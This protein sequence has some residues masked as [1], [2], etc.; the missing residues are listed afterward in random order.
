MIK[1]NQSAIVMISLSLFLFIGYNV[2]TAEATESND[3][4]VCED[5]NGEWKNIGGGEKGC[6]FD[7]ES[8]REKYSV[9]PGYSLDST[10]S[11]AEYGIEDLVTYDNE[12]N[13]IY[14][15]IE[16][17]SSEANPNNIDSDNDGIYDDEELTDEEEERL[18]D[19]PKVITGDDVEEEEEENDDDDDD[20]D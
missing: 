6:T 2:L 11:D 8:D 5:Y 12:G 13:K 14:P 15:N 20:D 19:A 9:R 18:A 7:N 4:K 17:D 3:K 1:L 10:G 16:T